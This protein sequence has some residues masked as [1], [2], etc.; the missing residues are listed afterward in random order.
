VAAV[1]F[2]FLVFFTNACDSSVSLLRDVSEGVIRWNFEWRRRLFFWE[3]NLLTELREVIGQVVL[4]DKKDRRSWLPDSGGEFRVKST[5]WTVVKLFVSMETEAPF[6]SKAFVSLWKCLAPS[7]V[8]AFSW[9]LLDRITTRQN[10]LRRK[11]PLGEEERCCVWCGT[12]AESVTHLYI[13]CDFA[14]QVW[15]EVFNGW[16]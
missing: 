13:Y 4:S 8:L 12:E 1:L 3:E 6:E 10:L 16:D 9:Q 11:I 2:P 7:K 15:I 14:R 5:H